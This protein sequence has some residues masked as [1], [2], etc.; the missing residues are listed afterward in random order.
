WS[1]LPDEELRT[2]AD[3]GKLSDPQVLREQVERLLKDDKARAFTENFVGQWLDLRE[4]DF[5]SPDANLYPEHDELLRISMVEE[6]HRFFQEVLDRDLS[7]MNFV[8]S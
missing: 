8:D 1:S 6:T 7:L 3:Q 4:I 2:L 5:T